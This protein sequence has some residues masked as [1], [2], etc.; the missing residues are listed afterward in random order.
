ML[1]SQCMKG[2]CLMLRKKRSLADA[3]ADIDAYANVYAD[4]DAYADAYA[5]AYSV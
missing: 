2:L 5:D 3:Y 4:I 1:L